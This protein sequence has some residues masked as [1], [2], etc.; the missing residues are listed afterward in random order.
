MSF[1]LPLIVS[2]VEPYIQD[3]LMPNNANDANSYDNTSNS[4]DLNDTDYYDGMGF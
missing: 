2:F 1:L 3:L 4:S